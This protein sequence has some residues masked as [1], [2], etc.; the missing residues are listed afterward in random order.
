MVHE[1]DVIKRP[2]WDETW[3]YVADI[4]AL[5]SR[6]VRRKAGCVLVTPDN[7]VVSTGYNGPPRN[8]R[9][10]TVL[11]GGFVE[12]DDSP[13]SEWCERA[14]TGGSMSYD[15][16]PS[17]HSEINALLRA[18]AS[19][20]QG[21]VAYVTSGPCLTCAKALSNSGITRVVYRITDVDVDRQ[22]ELTLD[23]FRHSSVLVRLIP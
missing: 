8:Y 4:I 6:C 14:K 19:R 2:T 11:D 13:C 20:L 5:R 16:C 1:P 17:V 12:S 10:V 23:F 18:D 21:G 22:P 3:M 7:Q 9:N 15:D